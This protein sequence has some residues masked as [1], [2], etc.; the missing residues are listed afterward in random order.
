MRKIGAVL[1]AR[2]GRGKLLTHLQIPGSVSQSFFGLAVC[3]DPNERRTYTRQQHWFTSSPSLLFV[4]KKFGFHRTSNTPLT[5]QFGMSLLFSVSWTLTET[6]D[7]EKLRG[8]FP[9]VSVCV[10]VSFY[11]SLHLCSSLPLCHAGLLLQQQHLTP[12]EPCR[13]RHHKCQDHRNLAL[14]LYKVSVTWVPH[15]EWKRR[16]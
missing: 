3:S 12:K 1:R 13:S 16:K 4:T 5:T 15:S 9:N 7:T 11:P 10:C 2:S 6:I 14:P 8:W